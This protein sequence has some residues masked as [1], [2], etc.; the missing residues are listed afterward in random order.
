MGEALFR[1][2]LA[3]IVGFFLAGIVAASAQ[4]LAPD[5]PIIRSLADVVGLRESFLPA[6][7]LCLLAFALRTWGEAVL[8]GAVYGQEA[9]PRVVASGPFRY[10]RHPLYAGTWLFS[11]AAVAPHVPLV[12]L[13]GAGIAFALALRSIAVHEEDHLLARHGDAWRRYA[14][15]VPRFLGR[16]SPVED[17]G[18]RPHARAWG[19][20]ALSNVGMASL[21]AY[22]LLTALDSGFWGIGALNV[23]LLAVW[24]AVV[25]VRRVRR[26]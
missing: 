2:R 9:A 14:Q 12:F 23:A 25:V 11:V 3:V 19:L 4:R 6:G 22:R 24:L 17:D 18:V 10:M 7:F 16:A 20:A 5:T 15:A 21:G 1:H 13:G 8:G 26:A